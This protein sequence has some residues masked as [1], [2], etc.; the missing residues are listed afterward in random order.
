MHAKG[1]GKG[2][3]GGILRRGAEWKAGLLRNM[4]KRF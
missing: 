2:G 4:L 3:E 1:K